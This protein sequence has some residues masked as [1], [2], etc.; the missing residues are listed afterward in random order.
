MDL[1]KLKTKTKILSHITEKLELDD[2]DSPRIESDIDE[3]EEMEDDGVKSPE[4][5]MTESQKL[6]ERRML[7]YG[8]FNKHNDPEAMIGLMAQRRGLTNDFAPAENS[9]TADFFN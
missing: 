7:Y 8:R 1:G 9:G 6:E 3:C 5:L 2:K 4:D